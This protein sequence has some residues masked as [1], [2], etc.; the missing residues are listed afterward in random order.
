M[1]MFLLFAAFVSLSCNDCR[2]QTK[3]NSANINMRGVAIQFLQNLNDAQKEKAQLLF[4]N[5]ERYHWFYIPIERKGVPLKDLNE[6]QVK[7]GMDLLHTALSDTSFN[8]TMAI[9]Q[10]ENVLRELENAS[11][12]Y[13]NPG[14]YY[15][16]IFGNPGDSIWGWRFEGHHVSFNFSSQNNRLVSGSPGF[17]GSN[18]AVVQSGMQK[19]LQILKEESLLGFELLHSL[20]AEQ[21]QKAI[22]STRAPG[23]I[24]TASSRKAMIQSLQGIV[25]SDLNSKQQKI[26]LQLLSIYIYRY[27]SQLASKMMQEIEEAGLNNLRFAWAGSEV[28][29]VG[30]PHYYRIQGPTIIIEYDNTQNNANHVHTVIRD[31]KNDFGGDQ[32]LEH[33][34]HSKH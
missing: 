11:P 31:L 23:D 19:G 27:K 18:P 1:K 17:M 9:I 22:F 4:D 30:H 25:Y 5:E 29:G 20:T 13:R 2:S 33:Y 26:F 28:A 21:K 34:R 7:I 10:L 24:V 8:K 3:N 15:F 12:D 6:K 14:N 16:T 32:L